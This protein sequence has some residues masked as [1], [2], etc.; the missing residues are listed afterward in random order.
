M[1]KKI[2]DF[3]DKLR[4]SEDEREFI[5]GLKKE[6]PEKYSKLKEKFLGYGVKFQIYD[7]GTL[8]FVPFEEFDEN[9][10][11][12]VDSTSKFFKI[13]IP[14]GVK[15]DD[16]MPICCFTRSQYMGNHHLNLNFGDNTHAT[17]VVGSTIPDFSG[18]QN[19]LSNMEVKTGMNSEVKIVILNSFRKEQRVAPLVRGKFGQNSKVCINVINLINGTKH[20]S[21]YRFI[22][23]AGAEVKL[24]VISF[25]R[26]S[27]RIEDSYRIDL[28]GKKSNALISIR[29]I[30]RDHSYQKHVAII[31]A[32]PASSGSTGIADT[33]GYLLQDESRF[34][35]WPS[36][37]VKNDDI[38]LDHQAYI[39]HI[40]D[41]TI[42]YLRS[43]GFTRESAMFLI[44]HSMIEPIK[45]QLP[46]RFQFEVEMIARLLIENKLPEI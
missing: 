22:A 5:L 28:E 6:L 36:L 41:E 44:V 8:G 33:A 31:E 38:H 19:V 24:H 7:R 1:D 46:E 11:R 10:R 32:G 9:A 21:D 2:E 37:I 35:V 45:N 29:G 4:I 17:V 34:E 39:G 20:T 43:R 26:N 18:E 14:E 27:D 16:P 30:S 40:P 42:E 23:G 25:A 13:E 15:F 3:L 12:R